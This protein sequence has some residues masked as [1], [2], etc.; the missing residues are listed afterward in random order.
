MIK[1]VSPKFWQIRPPHIA[2]RLLSPL[3]A[4]Y[5]LVVAER[6]KTL[7]PPLLKPV[8]CIGNVTLGGAGKTP[9]VMAVCS[10][11][12]EAGVLAHIVSRGYGGS[13]RGV[14]SVDPSH[15][16]AALVGD[17]AL[18]MAQQFPVWVARRR[19]DAAQA[20][21]SNGAEVVVMDDGFQNPSLYKNFSL[22]VVDGDVG[23]GNGFVFPAGPL[24]ETL[25]EALTRADAVLIV[26]PDNA[27]VR[28][29]VDRLHSVPIFT[30]QPIVSL[31]EGT[32]GR[33][34]AFAGIGRPEKFKQSLEQAGIEVAHWQSFPDHHVYREEELED[35]RLQ[36][37]PLLTTEKDYAR[38]TQPQRNGIVPVA[39]RLQ[40]D[41]PE[42]LL[43]LLRE[44]GGIL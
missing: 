2:A 22:V 29:K 11:L 16:D 40:I 10:L 27:G 33:V 5:A 13:A 30:A 12:Q 28:A 41:Q 38:L 18:V 34:C 3:G 36:G 6:L 24:R 7:M 17:E 37:L 9:A 43:S 8:V 23:F 25:A 19:P 44:Q 4:L 21:I 15:H 35:M 42:Q 1:L 14:V 26:G 39:Y 32:P 20:A 31:P